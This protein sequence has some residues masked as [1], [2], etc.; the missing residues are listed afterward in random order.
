MNPV[1]LAALMDE[2]EKVAQS[3]YPGLEDL[4]KKLRPGDILVGHSR[5][6]GV[7]GGLVG[8]VLAV[9]QGTKDYH[10]AMYVG[11]GHVV[12]GHASRGITKMPLESFADLYK[13]K[14]LKVKARRKWRRRAVEFAEQSVGKEFN[15]MG[16]LRQ[17]L[18]A[19]AAN[20]PRVREATDSYFCSQL[21]SNAYDKVPF[22]KKTHIGD[23]RPVDFAKSS[24]TK[25]LGEV[26]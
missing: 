12:D 3:A 18:P 14:A 2:L 11:D 7:V 19:R 24:L 8:G 6:P 20:G 5:D 10:S 26:R 9:R 25:T 22:A 4:Q 15:L 1:T 13:F 23:V 16:V 17:A 21:I